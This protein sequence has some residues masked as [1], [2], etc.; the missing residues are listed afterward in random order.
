[1]SSF[2]VRGLVLFGVSVVFVNR[3]LLLFGLQRKSRKRPLGD[4]SSE[5]SVHALGLDQHIPGI[6]F[7]D[8][9]AL[10]SNLGHLYSRASVSNR[11]RCELLVR[12]KIGESLIFCWVSEN[13]RLFHY[14]VVCGGV[15]D[16]SVSPEVLEIT[17]AFHSFVILRQRATY[18]EQLSQVT[19][20]VGN[21]VCNCRCLHV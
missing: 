2:D 12:N 3:N 4:E 9:S 20:E 16:G 17:Q 11:D 21:R 13:G 7:T 8:H 19:V 10:V 1:M 18:P 6:L 14:R 15:S 5:L